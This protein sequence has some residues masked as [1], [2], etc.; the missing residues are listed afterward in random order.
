MKIILIKLTNLEYQLK[1]VN[2]SNVE[3]NQKLD[4]LLSKNV[5]P[6]VTNE[7]LIESHGIN[8]P[9]NTID[10]FNKFCDLLNNNENIRL[11]IVSNLRISLKFINI[12]TYLC[13]VKF[14][15]SFNGYIIH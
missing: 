10:E 5:I 4:T 13:Y 9:V 11:L 1:A 6:C 3:I 14:F 15:S 8:L 12:N 7:N 2:K